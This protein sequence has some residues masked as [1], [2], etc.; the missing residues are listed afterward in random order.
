MHQITGLMKVKGRSI[1]PL[2]YK[3][4]G[5]GFFLGWVS[6]ANKRPSCGVSTVTEAFGGKQV[7][8]LP[9]RLWKPERGL[10][11]AARTAQASLSRLQPLLLP[12][13]DLCKFQM[14]E[15]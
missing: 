9:R 1:K 4:S 7:F 12:E 5:F 2:S 6:I 11:G 13:C 3:R 15:N 14:M 8:P 10:W